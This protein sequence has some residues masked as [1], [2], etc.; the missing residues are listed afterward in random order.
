MWDFQEDDFP[1][2]GEYEKPKMWICDDELITV[3]IKLEKSDEVRTTWIKTIKIEIWDTAS[4]DN[5]DA[6]YDIQVVELLRLNC[7]YAHKQYIYIGTTE[8]DA[9]RVWVIDKDTFHSPK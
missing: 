8:K 1:P 5:L 9:E 2:Y 4:K 3:S 7:V 6:N